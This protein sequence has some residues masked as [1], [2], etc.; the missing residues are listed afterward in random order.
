[1]SPIYEYMCSDGHVSEALRK[2]ADREMAT[3]CD[4]CGQL[5]TL[6]VSRP[7]G[8]PDGIYSYAPNVG[9]P[10][11]FEKRRQ[12]IKDGVTVYPKHTPGEE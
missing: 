5:T 2:M 11:A 10:V 8:S 6:I 12:A 7:S 3:L 4:E 9:D 1:M